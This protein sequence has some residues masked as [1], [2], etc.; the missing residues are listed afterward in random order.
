MYIVRQST[1]KPSTPCIQSDLASHIAVDDKTALGASNLP[2]ILAV[3]LGPA[4]NRHN[5]PAS[6]LA[7]AYELLRV[8]ANL[9][10][11]HG[12]TLRVIGYGLID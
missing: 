3:L 6:Y 7:A 5:G 1:H 10:S 11:D 4:T 12:E 8:G 9:C 2:T